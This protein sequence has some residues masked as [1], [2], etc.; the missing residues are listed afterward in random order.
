MIK[1]KKKFKYI[2][3]YFNRNIKDYYFKYLLYNLNLEKN[4]IE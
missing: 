4:Q 3:L 1:N 2:Y